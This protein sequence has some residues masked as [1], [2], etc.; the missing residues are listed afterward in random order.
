MNALFSFAREQ[1]SKEPASRSSSEKLS[2]VDTQPSQ[3]TNPFDDLEDGIKQEDID[4]SEGMKD[5]T[6]EEVGVNPFWEQPLINEMERH[7]QEL[8]DLIESSLTDP[9]ALQEFKDHLKVI[10]EILDKELHRTATF[11]RTSECLEYFLS[12]NM[13]EKAYL[14]STRQRLYCSEVRLTLLTF[15][16]SLLLCPGPP[17]FIHQQVLRPL[18]RLLRACE[19]AHDQ[20]LDSNLVSLLQQICIL[21]QENESLLELFFTVGSGQVPSKF[22]VF[23]LLIRYMHNL[24]EPGMR[25]RDAMLLC[26]SIAGRSPHSSLCDFIITDTEFC[27]VRTRR[28]TCN[29]EQILSTSLSPSK[30][31]FLLFSSFKF[32]SL[33]LSLLAVSSLLLSLLSLFSPLSYSLSYLSLSLFSPSLSSLLA[34]SSLPLSLLSLF[35]PLSYSLSYLSLSLFSPSLSFLPVSLLSSLSSLLLSLL[36]SFS[37]PLSLISFPLSSLQVLATGLSATYSQL[38]QVVSLVTDEWES[39]LASFEQR[40]PEMKKFMQALSY[41]N[42]VLQV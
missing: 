12:E 9:F 38:P 19:M 33:P 13:L 11:G 21:I 42:S 24:S 1:S 36:S 29:K 2:D 35:S 30:L 41:C 31:I 39:S 23:T 37:P 15:S 26:L 7:W 8:S 28:S 34:V 10:A 25:A 18:T 27:Q 40:I 3:S 32:F 5:S 14:F 4:A 6:R 17:L 20:W 22:L 16:T